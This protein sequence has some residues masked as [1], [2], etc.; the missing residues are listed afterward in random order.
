MTNY[1]QALHKKACKLP[2]GTAHL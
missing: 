2:F 1:I